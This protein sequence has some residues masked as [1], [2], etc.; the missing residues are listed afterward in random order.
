MRR[1]V[2]ETVVFIHLCTCVRGV[3]ACVCVICNV[4]EECGVKCLCLWYGMHGVCIHLVILKK[5]KNNVPP[6]IR[7]LV[8]DGLC[9]KCMCR[10]I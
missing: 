8:Q 4:S 7:N 3:Y 5:K 9:A 10:L 1:C 6:F 2:I